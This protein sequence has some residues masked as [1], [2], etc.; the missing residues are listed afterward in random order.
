MTQ[1]DLVI[2]GGRIVHP[3]GIVDA[4]VAIRDGRIL[5]IG[6]A[7]NMPLATEIIDAAGW[8]IVLG[9]GGGQALGRRTMDAMQALARSMN[10]RSS[11][12]DGGIVAR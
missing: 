8:H 10:S 1:A 12:D 11:S 6:A 7:D 4:S 3:D 2:R 5:S 9:E